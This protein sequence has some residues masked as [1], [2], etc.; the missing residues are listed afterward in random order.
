[1]FDIETTG[2]SFKLHAPHQITMLVMHDGKSE[3]YDWKVKPFEDALIDDKAL[4][5]GGITRDM[6]Q[7]EDYK[8]E[9]MVYVEMVKMLGGK[10]D[11]YD[12]TDKFH[13]MGYNNRGF[14]D[15]FL[16]EFFARRGDKYYGSWFWAD[17]IDVMVL[18]SNHLRMQRSGMENFKLMTVCREMGI[19]VDESQLHNSKYD[20]W[21][22]A[23]LYNRIEGEDENGN[24]A[25]PIGEFGE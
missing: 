18:A 19:D 23:Q 4:E 1:M 5:V 25:L 12:K 15:N 3:W 22:T 16:R 20:V 2:L 21:L 13:L 7:G 6:L 10:V 14:D 17:T 24:W 8:D 9:A 11:K